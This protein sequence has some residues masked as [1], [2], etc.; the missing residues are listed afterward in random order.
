MACPSFK[1]LNCE[2]EEWSSSEH[3]NIRITSMGLQCYIHK[4]EAV[5]WE[6][7][8]QTRPYY[9]FEHYQLRIR[10]LQVR[11]FLSFREGLMLR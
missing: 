10:Q 3:G 11:L 8:F 2:H 7:S 5:E 6:I 9:D 4:K 1:N